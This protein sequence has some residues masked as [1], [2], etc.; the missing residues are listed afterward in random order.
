MCIFTKEAATSTSIVVSPST[1]QTS[2]SDYNSLP[3]DSSSSRC[4]VP[5]SEIEPTSI[6]W[7]VCVYWLHLCLHKT[8]NTTKNL[9]KV[10]SNA[11]F[12]HGRWITFK[13]KAKHLTHAQNHPHWFQIHFKYTCNLNFGFQK[14]DV[15]GLLLVPTK[16]R[17]LQPFVVRTDRVI[18]YGYSILTRVGTEE[19]W[20]FVKFL[21]PF[22]WFV[23]FFIVVLGVCMTV[24]LWLTDKISPND[25]VSTVYQAVF[26]TCR[27]THANNKVYSREVVFTHWPTP[28][29][30][31]SG[32]LWWPK[33]PQIRTKHR[34]E[35]FFFLCG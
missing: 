35:Y 8:K 10:H 11:I 18:E 26:H 21:T 28:A 17:I 29:S 4:N 9:T 20:N 23:W 24:S 32:L 33:W 16:N 12:I 3:F 13:T 30:L 5:F 2:S 6:W 19:G 1:E 27:S 25:G 15:I 31:F 14:I 34:R 7:K 22:S